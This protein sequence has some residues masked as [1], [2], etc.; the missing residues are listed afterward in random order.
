MQR[1]PADE[2]DAAAATERARQVGERGT[3]VGEEHDAE[4]REEHVERAGRER[5]R[6]RVGLLEAS[7]CDS[8]GTCGGPGLLEHGRG[9]VGAEHGSLRTDAAGELE[10]RLSAAAPDVD[11]ALACRDPG[12]IHRAPAERADLAVDQVLQLDPVARALVVPVLDLLGVRA[13]VL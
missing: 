4:A 6:L 11:H 9:H 3:R 8:G 7:V 5:V 10:R 12:A 13:A 2:R 1:P